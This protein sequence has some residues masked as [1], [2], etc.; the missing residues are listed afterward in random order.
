MKRLSSPET[1][2]AT[3][4]AE[5][6]TESAETEAAAQADPEALALVE[7]A[8]QRF[9]D[10]L[11][12]S[13]AD[14]HGVVLRVA[15]DSWADLAQ[16]LKDE[17]FGLFNFLSAIDWMISPFG[18]DM[19]SAVDTALGSS[20]A[21]G[22]GDSDGDDDGND[23]DGSDDDGDSVVEEA[24]GTGLAGGDSRFQ[25]LARV[26][27][28]NSHR[29]VIV[30]TDLPEDDLRAPSWVPVFAGADWHERET[31]EMFGIN[32][33]GHPGLSHIYLPGDFEGNPL[34]K[35]Y[36]LLARKVKP[37]PGIVDVELMPDE[38]DASDSDQ[39]S[40]EGDGEASA[41]DEEQS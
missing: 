33:E 29:S 27:D 19:D 23:D 15:R 24:E 12:G 13:H 40:D 5:P 35:D 7:R 31:W 41:A 18:R 4:S 32:F 2:E 9:G 28:V 30:K 20:A 36:P 10:N 26:N 14:E 39:G 11:A 3:E 8:Q 25:L 38:G 6:E 1:T 34:R 21:T 37:W 16:W 22:T 17:G